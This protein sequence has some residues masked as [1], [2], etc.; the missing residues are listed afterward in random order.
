MPCDSMT[1]DKYGRCGSIIMYRKAVPKLNECNEIFNAYCRANGLSEGDPW[2]TY[3]YMAWASRMS[4]EFAEEK[5][6]AP[7]QKQLLKDEY[8]TWLKGKS[9]R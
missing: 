8:I 4:E 7:Y 6:I 1:T 2:V 5:G 3:D 9:A